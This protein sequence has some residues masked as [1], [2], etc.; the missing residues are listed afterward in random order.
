M[1]SD[2]HKR[3]LWCMDVYCAIIKPLFVWGDA[4]C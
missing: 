3:P 2:V 1:N 4:G